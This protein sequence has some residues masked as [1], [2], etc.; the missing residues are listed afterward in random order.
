MVSRNP[1]RKEHTWFGLYLWEIKER[2]LKNEIA[3]TAKFKHYVL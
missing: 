2:K 1:A 3:K